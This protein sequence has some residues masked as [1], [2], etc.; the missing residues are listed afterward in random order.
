MVGW[1][2]WM[3][4]CYVVLSVVAVIWVAIV[5]CSAADCYVVVYALCLLGLA[6]IVA[7]CLCWL[8]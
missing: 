6:F 7:C 8:V 4:G 1:L 5:G 2:C 3:V